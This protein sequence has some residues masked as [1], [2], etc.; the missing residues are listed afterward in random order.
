VADV[1]IDSSFAIAFMLEEEHSGYARD[2]VQ[3]FGD[4]SLRAPALIC[5][6]VANALQ[7]KS[8]RGQLP[9]DERAQHLVTFE[10]LGIHLEPA[11]T[12]EMLLGLAQLS[13]RTGLTIYDAS[14]LDLGLVWGAELATI[15]R[16]LAEAA[17]AE[18]VTVHC[19][20]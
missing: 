6:E 11:P 2:A 10:L 9:P 3:S 17:R 5:W 16:K 19:P 1:V 14:Y 8:R 13:D 15:D 4:A 7:V 20:F 12:S 18:G